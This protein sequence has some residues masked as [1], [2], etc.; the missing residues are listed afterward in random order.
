MNA[1]TTYNRKNLPA[2]HNRGRLLSPEWQLML[3]ILAQIIIFLVIYITYYKTPYTATALYFNDLTKIFNGSIPY[4]D[5]TYEYPPFSLVFLILPRLISPTYPIFS[6]IY[7]VEVLVFVL[8]GL[9]FTYRIARRLG[10][11]P[12]KLMGIY[13]LSILAMGPIVAAQYDIFPAILTLLTLYFFWIG[14]QKLAWVLLALGVMT[15]IYPAVLAPVFLLYYVCNRQYRSLWKGIGVF[16][17]VCLVVIVPFLV[18]S[19]DSLWNLVTYHSQ[20]GIQLESVYSS[21]LLILGKMGL[22]SINLVFNFGSWNLTGSLA[23]FLSRLSTYLLFIFLIIAYWFIYEQMRP[24]KSQ[25]SRFGAYSLLVVGIT[26]ITSKILSPQYLIWLVP[27]VPLIFTRWRWSILLIFL[28]IGGL[29]YYIFPDHYLDLLN[30]YPVPVVVLF[31]RNIL[32]IALIALTGV[33]L[34]RMKASE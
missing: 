3:F 32:L 8:I 5:F 2:N 30:L 19:F 33:S 10:K 1:S 12:W 17:G 31:L 14:K 16:V 9:Y 27:F 6:T 23:D 15:K 28:A 25:F 34:K 11:A 13:T 4:R 22:T 18:L 7:Q 21:F 20:R 26:L 24:G 29:T